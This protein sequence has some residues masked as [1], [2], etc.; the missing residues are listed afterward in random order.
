MDIF[1][2]VT[3][4]LERVP[5]QKTIAMARTTIMERIS[6]IEE[7]ISK[8]RLVAGSFAYSKNKMLTPNGKCR[9]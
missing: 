2:V 6:T 9:I 4:Q 5:E 7:T 8:N 1:Y 3:V